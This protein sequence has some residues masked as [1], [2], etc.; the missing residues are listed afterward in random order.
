MDMM[1]ALL[2]QVVVEAGAHDRVNVP[3]SVAYAGDARTVVL[4]DAAGKRIPGQVAD[5]TLRFLVTLKA[6]QKAE[7]AVAPGILEGPA[8][9]WSDV[10]LRLGERPV[11]KYMNAPLDPAKREET[12]KVFHHVYSPDGSRLLTKG[13]GGQ[14][15]H[16]RGVFYGFN[17]VTYGEGKSCDVWHCSKDA[18]QAHDAVL[19][20]EEGPVLGR[21]RLGIRWNG[22]GKDVFAVE[23]RELTA[24]AVPG[25]ILIDFVSSLEAKLGPVKL[26]GDP[27]HAGF[28][29][30]ADNEVSA[31]T[32]KQTVFT[33]PDGADKAGATR[34]WPGN[35][36]HVNL[37]WNAMSFTLG[38]KR[39][40]TLYLDRPDNPKEARFSERDYGRFGS[41]FA[42]TVEA[43][44]PLVVRY[45]LWIQEGPIDVA[46]CASKSADFLDP[47]KASAK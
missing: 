44:K 35:K 4:T 34:N 29:F 47:P 31:K 8:F 18:H 9:K 12:Y 38:E 14:F 41:Y 27:Q 3:V 46:A 6:G 17:K 23:T 37:P 25:G 2:L 22:V 43:G 33:R 15:T 24:W 28:H 19:A 1:L 20:V 40:T 11:L 32:A 30:R 5:Q 16:H 26:D 39:Y 21:H 13:P 10:E 36:E 45:R 7:Y 42:A